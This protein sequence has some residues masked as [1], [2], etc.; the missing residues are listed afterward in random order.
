MS[1]HMV[2]V[3]CHHTYSTSNSP[4]HSL[5]AAY[6]ELYSRVTEQ[7]TDYVSTI[8]LVYVGSVP[9]DVGAGPGVGPSI[10]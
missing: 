6:P 9:S 5:T 4:Q 10:S 7:T 2:N 1:Y 3:T 8:I